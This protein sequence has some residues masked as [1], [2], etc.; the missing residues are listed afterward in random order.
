MAIKLMHA[1]VLVNIISSDVMIIDIE[2]EI[3]IFQENRTKSISRFLWASATRFWYHITLEGQRIS[4]GGHRMGFT[5]QWVRS[6]QV[7]RSLYLRESD[8]AKCKGLYI[9]NYEYWGEKI[10]IE[11]RRK[12][13]RRITSVWQWVEECHCISKGKLEMGQS[14]VKL[15]QQVTIIGKRHRV[16]LQHFQKSRR[17]LSA[18]QSIATAVVVFAASDHAPRRCNV[19]GWNMF[20]WWI[21]FN[22]LSESHRWQSFW[23]FWSACFTVNRSKFCKKR[24]GSNSKINMQ[25]VPLLKVG[26]V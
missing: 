26:R 15:H 11:S 25:A 4:T 8:H 6:H 23:V 22:M 7:W 1:C 16:F 18:N 3:A 24:D 10:E 5:Q 17:G 20:A 19:I 21:F 2:I 14:M 12:T 9:F 13:N